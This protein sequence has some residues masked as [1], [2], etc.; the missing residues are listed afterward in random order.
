M[1]KNLIDY[2]KQ[3]EGSVDTTQ[4][5]IRKLSGGRTR[6]INSIERAEKDSQAIRN[7][8]NYASKIKK[9]LAKSALKVTKD[10]LFAATVN[11]IKKRAEFD[12]PI[13][14][15]ALYEAV[16]N[17]DTYMIMTRGTGFSS[18]ISVDI[19]LN[20]TAGRL[21]MWAKAVKS[22]RK[23]LGTK[24][25][26]KKVSEARRA[27]AAEQAS[28][29]WAGIYN[30]R[31][32][33]SK[34]TETVEARLSAA[35]KIAPFWEL[36]DKGALPMSSDR[37]G[38]P[39][40]K[41]KHLNFV[42]RAEKEASKRLNDSFLVEKEKYISL[43]SNY[44]GIINQALSDLAELNALIEEIRIDNRVISN[45]DKRATRAMKTEYNS[46]L[47]KAIQLISEGL[48]TTRKLQLATKGSYRG[49]RFS[50]ETVKELLY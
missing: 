10:I 11:A 25:P 14:R 23:S 8:T 45:L 19:N 50:Q 2:T 32:V 29:A 1:F 9:Q 4:K 44:D 36:L 43:I 42:D 26:N 28:R 48:T 39:T 13:Y 49:K 35:A 38:Y 27:K 46:K 24:V 37:G 3:L 33:N 41:N 20:K 17:N 40:P 12:V 34:F 5:F 6:L 15:N 22:V 31:G 16:E 30:K 47:R 18:I 7:E 21:D